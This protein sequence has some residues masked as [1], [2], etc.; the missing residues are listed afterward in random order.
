[1][2]AS[3]EIDTFGMEEEAEATS[4]V[5]RRPLDLTTPADIVTLLMRAQMGGEL[6]ES[7]ICQLTDTEI[8]R[9]REA[10]LTELRQYS[11]SFRVIE[12][13]LIAAAGARMKE[14]KARSLPDPEFD[15]E[16]ED[17]YSDY[18]RNVDAAIEAAFLLPE[19]EA[20]KVVKFVPKFV[21]PPVDA[22]H[23]VGHPNSIAALR[24]K[25]AG[26]KVDELLGLA[27]KRSLLD[28]KVKMVR[29]KGAILEAEVV[30]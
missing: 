14:R 8:P 13:A 10:L 9:V 17:V 24:R 18:T 4:L 19:A 26:S 5:T 21:P 1:M 30:G 12:T 16:L 7:Y 25:Y 11:E 20:K 15:I 23:E 28:T 2:T 29:R 6:V 3:A 22:H 27:L